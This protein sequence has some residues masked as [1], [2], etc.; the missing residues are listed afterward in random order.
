MIGFL[1]FLA[2]SKALLRFSRFCENVFTFWYGVDVFRRGR[3]QQKAENRTV[4]GVW[5][6]GKTRDP[7]TYD[8]KMI[9]VLC[10]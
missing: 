3:S 6:V 10:G 9:C 2:F 7:E 1:C 8:G 4:S 5:V